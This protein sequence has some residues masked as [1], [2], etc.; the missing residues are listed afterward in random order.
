[1]KQIAPVSNTHVSSKNFQV[2]PHVFFLMIAGSD[3]RA[4]TGGP[5]QQA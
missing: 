2:F 1:M 5:E 3:T 4:N